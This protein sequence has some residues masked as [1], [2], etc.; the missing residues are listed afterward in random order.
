MAWDLISFV[1]GKTRKA[2]L[3]ELLFSERTPKMIAKKTGETL[4]HISR[5]LSELEEKKLVECLTP[6]NSKNRFYGITEEGK[7]IFRKAY[8]IDIE[9]K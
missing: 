7:A 3:Y 8:L 4:S 9:S 2:C 5:A 6:N 1:Q